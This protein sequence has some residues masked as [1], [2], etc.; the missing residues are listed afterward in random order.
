MLPV[1]IYR[2]SCCHEARTA[3]GLAR[4][5]SWSGNQAGGAPPTSLG[6]GCFLGSLGFWAL[7]SPFLALPGPFFLFTPPISR[8]CRSDLAADRSCRDSV[9]LSLAV[10][11]V[12]SGVVRWA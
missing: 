6:S 3:S 10:L 11:L 12:W 5:E 9:A 1:L 7:P 8:R 4:Y 2:Q